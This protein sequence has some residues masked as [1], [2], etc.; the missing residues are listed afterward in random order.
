MIMERAPGKKDRE[1]VNE[2]LFHGK[3]E[4]NHDRTNHQG[5][6]PEY[7]AKQAKEHR[8]QEECIH[9]G[10]ENDNAYD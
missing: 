5:K 6:Q 10:N 2:L 7:R 4:C 3:G 9:A 1:L 8:S